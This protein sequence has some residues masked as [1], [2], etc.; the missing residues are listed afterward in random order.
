MND[1]VRDVAL[2]QELHTAVGLAQLGLGSLQRIDGAN[3]FYHL[4]LLLLA[5]A[6]ERLLKVILCLHAKSDTEAYPTLAEIKGYG[7]NL[8]SLLNKVTEPTVFGK[9]WVSTTEAGAVDH[10]FG[11]NGGRA[12]R[13][14]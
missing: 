13:S 10:A 11:F 8:A 3:D 9:T 6:K 4:P 14:T 5:E 12:T 2:I 7:H 1:L